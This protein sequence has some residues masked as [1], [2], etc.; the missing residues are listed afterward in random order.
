ML[1]Q[2]SQNPNIEDALP[3]MSESASFKM[4]AGI[5][6]KRSEVRCRGEAVVPSARLPGCVTTDQTY[7]TQQ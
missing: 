5:I 2:L 3:R 7:H 4:E 1:P 6:L